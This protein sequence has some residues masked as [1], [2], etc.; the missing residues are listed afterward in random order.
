MMDNTRKPRRCGRPMLKLAALLSVLVV[1]A[2]LIYGQELVGMI[3]LGKQI[4]QISHENT[5]LAGPWPRASDACINCHGFEGNARSQGYARLAG[6]PEAYLR[7]QLGDFASGE[8]SDPVMT[9]LAVSMSDREVDG[10]AAYFS[11]LAPQPNSTFKPDAARVARG[12]AL[13]KTNN[14][15]ACHGAQLEGKGVYPRLAGQGYDYLRDQLARFKSGARRDASGAMPAIAGALT[16]QDMDDLSQF[17][18][19]R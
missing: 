19:S 11:K 13:A 15:A 12:E 4:E 7:K 3:R 2:G 10:L 18:A 9:T 6:Q 8:R 14:C 5:R 1:V 17:L 16:P